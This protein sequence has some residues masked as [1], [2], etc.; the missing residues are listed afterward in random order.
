M[1]Q[2]TKTGTHNHPLLKLR[3]SQSPLPVYKVTFVHLARVAT[4]NRPGVDI[5]GTGCFPSRSSPRLV[6]PPCVPVCPSRRWLTG[7]N[8]S[9]PAGRT[10]FMDR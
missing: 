7:R 1:Q 3:L 9:S 10:T 6:C 4:V 5:S 2:E 8:T